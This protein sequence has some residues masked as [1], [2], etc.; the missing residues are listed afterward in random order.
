MRIAGKSP[1]QS[2]LSYVN[3][4]TFFPQLIAGPIVHHAEMMPQFADRK[5]IDWRLIHLGVFLFVVGLSKKI[6]VA[7]WRSEVVVFAYKDLAGLS[8]VE[9]WVTALSYSLQLWLDFS[10]YT[11][12]ALGLG[13]IFGIRLPFNFNQ[14]YRALD[15]QD[16]W[17]RWHMTLTKFLTEYVYFPLGGSRMGAVRTYGNI[18]VVFAVS[19]FWHG[20]GW[21]FIL[22]GLAHGVASCVLRL[23]RAWGAV[24]LPRVVAWGVTFLFVVSTWVLFRAETVEQALTLLRTMYLGGET[25]VGTGLWEE[26]VVGEL[27]WMDDKVLGPT[28][29]KAV[30]GGLVVAAVYGV[31][32]FWRFDAPKLIERWRPGLLTTVTICVMLSLSLIYM[33]KASEFLY[34]QF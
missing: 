4:V 5:P 30:L 23:W 17:R 29:A 14:P 13:M 16:F 18:M 21:T 32:R 22:W 10:A 12:M 1:A 15:I 26:F 7:D 34:F 11:D 31:G 6:L 28:R 8:T 20:A 3:F 9:A 33:Q 24:T 2:G 19:G 27:K 25:W